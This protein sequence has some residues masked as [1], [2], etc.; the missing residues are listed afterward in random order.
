MLVIDYQ[1][2]CHG[3]MV[4]K[5]QK[6]VNKQGKLHCVN[7]WGTTFIVIEPNKI[8]EINTLWEDE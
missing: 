2:P 4:I 7:K 1:H 8:L 6:I 3:E 5:C